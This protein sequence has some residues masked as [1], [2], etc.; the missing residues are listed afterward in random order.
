MRERESE[1]GAREATSYLPNRR[2]VLVK[3]I[4]IYYIAL[5]SKLATRLQVA[6]PDGRVV[7]V[8]VAQPP[9]NAQGDLRPPAPGAQRRALIVVEELAEA[10]E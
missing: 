4:I 10:G 3:A 6:V 5:Y 1:D 9:R 7:L 2:V 8:Q